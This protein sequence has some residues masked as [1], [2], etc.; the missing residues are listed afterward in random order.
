[1][2]RGLE[3]HEYLKANIAVPNT[4]NDIPVPQRIPPN[5]KMNGILPSMKERYKVLQN[6]NARVV[7][8][9]LNY[10]AWLN[11]DYLLFEWN[12]SA[13]KVGG[14]WAKWL[15]ENVGISDSYARQLRELSTK[16][17]D[18]EEKNHHF[19]IPFSELWKRRLKI[20][21]MLHR[22]DTTVAFWK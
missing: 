3:L 14:S 18:F 8:A 4:R 9:A 2:S 19:T 1:V 10:G 12:K 7:G 5:I 17:G 22:V 21:E 6:L 11:A 13:G 20:Q 15:K 16:F